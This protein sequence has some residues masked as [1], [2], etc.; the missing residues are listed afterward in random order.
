M[1]LTLDVNTDIY[2]VY[3]GERFT[4]VLASTLRCI[5]A[6]L[7]ALSLALALVLAL[8]WPCPGPG[9]KG[10]LQEAPRV[11]EPAPT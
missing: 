4:L 7:L 1:E 5:L 8:S 11:F 2:P 9:L 6:L 10:T 3:L